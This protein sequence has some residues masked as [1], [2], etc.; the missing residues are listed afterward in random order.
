MTTNLLHRDGIPAGLPGIVYHP[1]ELLKPDPGN[2]RLHSKKQ[3]GQIARSIKSF[4][5]NVP[6]L[7]D[8]EL[9]VVAG[10]GRLLAARQLGF[11]AAID[12]SHGMA[13]LAAHLARA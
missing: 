4:G 3:I 6:V 9:R 12:F 2:P 8:A 13:E 1:I 10:H 11:R 5:F 7:I